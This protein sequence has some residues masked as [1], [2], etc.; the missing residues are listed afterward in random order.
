LSIT[1]ILSGTREGTGPAA[2]FSPSL[3]ATLTRPV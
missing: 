3:N 2:V 1:I